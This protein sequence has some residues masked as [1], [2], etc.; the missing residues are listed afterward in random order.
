MLL[1]MASLQIT[2]YHNRSN[3]Y[4]TCSR[5]RIALKPF[6]VEVA[7]SAGGPVDSNHRRVTV[8][9]A[10]AAL[11]AVADVRVAVGVPAGWACSLGDCAFPVAALSA[12][13][14]ATSVAEEVAADEPQAAPAV[15]CLAV[16][17]GLQAA[18]DVQRRVVRDDLRPVARDVQ[19]RAVRDDLR[20]VA[21]DVPFPAAP[22]ACPVHLGDSYRDVQADLLR[23]DL[24]RVGLVAGLAGPRSTAR[25]RDPRGLLPLVGKR[26]I[27]K[28]NRETIEH[29]PEGSVT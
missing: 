4:R 18:R 13:A 17:D 5:H 14:D 12:V 15:H 29:E 22:A 9:P 25:W 27:L 2:N 28:E 24:H 16:L 19:Y 11:L 1:S 10:A 6:P 8:E 3:I 26:E 20:P 7:C 21:L 23:G